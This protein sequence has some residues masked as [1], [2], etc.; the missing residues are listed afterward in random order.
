MKADGKQLS[1]PFS[2]GSGG[3]RFEANIQATFV[4][5]ML[6]SGYAPCLPAWP[7]VEIKLQGAVAGYGTDDLIVFVENPANNDRRK[8]LGQVKNSIQITAKSKIF[9]E[10]LQAAWNDFNNIEVFAKGRDVIA[11]ITGPINATD[12]DGVN[13]LLEQARH[14]RDADEFLTQI[15]RANFCSNN[16][17]N[18]LEA[19]KGHL[20]IANS[21]KEVEDQDLYD[22]LKHFHLLGYDLAKRGS[23]VASL[24]QSHIAQFNKDIPDKIWYQILSVVQ[25]FNQN[26]GSITPD[27]LPNDL[28]E[29][30]REPVI[31]HIPQSLVKEDGKDEDVGELVLTDWNK[32]PSAQK[33]SLA[34]L[35]GSWDES[36]EDD[37]EVVTKIT[38]ED[39]NGWISDLREAL[40]IHDCP[41]SYK[42]GLWSFKDRLQTW[43]ELGSR[44][45]D[46]HL[47]TLK[48]AALEVLRIDD[49]SFDLPGEERY[50][51]SIHGKVL[52]HSGSL[53]EGLAESLAL[54]GSRAVSLTHCTQ[55]KPDAISLLSVRELFEDGDWIRWGSLNRLLPVLSEAHPDE[56]LKAV[57]S[58]IVAMP[59]PFD[60]LFEQ[61]DTGVFG[62]NYITGLL[63][64]LEG[65]AWE[66]THLSRT[67][68]LLAEIAS[69]DPGGN[70]TN[71]PG[72][73]LTAIFL[74][75]LPHTLASLEKRQATL[76]TICVE[77]PEV[78]WK[79]LESLLPGQQSSSSGTHKPSWRGTI[80]DDWEKGVTNGEYWEQSRFCAELIVELAEFDVF[81]LAILTSKYD[82][83]PPPASDI[84]REKLLSEHCLKLSEEERMPLWTALVKLI[85][86]H[87][88]FPDAEWSLGDETL[89]PIEE[90]SNKLAP[91]SPRLLHR[92]IFSEA[93]AYLY[94][95]GGDWKK[96][97]K[98]LFELRKAA[99]GDILGEGGLPLVL[100]FAS[101]VSN[102]HLVGEVL[103]DFDQRE[104]DA[105]ILP[106]LLDI[107]D[108]EIWPLIKAYAS[109][110]RFMGGWQW[111]D[112]IDKAGWAPMQIAL[113][114]CA[115][116]FEKNAWDRVAQL[117]GENE[118]G[119]WKNTSIHPYNSDDDTEHALE[120]L[121]EFGRPSAAI[122][123]LTQDLFV[124][125]VINPDLACKA[126][127]ALVRAD[128]TLGR[129]D[130]YQ[131]TE[132]IKELQVN[133]ATDQ[134]KLFQVEWA[135]VAL[136]DQ[137]GDGSPITLENRL[138]SDPNFF[139]ELIQLVFRAEGAEP[140]EE[141]SE[142]HRN[143]ATNAYRLLSAWSVI[144]GARHD[145]EFNQEAFT[146]WLS[147]VE[148]VVKASGHY[149]VAMIQLGDVLVNSP[150]GNG[151]FI[152][153]VIAEAMNNKER[154]S[155]RA[156]YRT[157]VRNA[158]GVYTV[159]PE[160]KPERELAEK[161]RGQA[162]EIENAGY[163]RLATTLRD[164]ATSYDADAERIISRG[165]MPS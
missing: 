152:H 101:T 133:A 116:P 52:P 43:Q 159:D 130:S 113:L 5:L 111:F 149:D 71:R 87:R 158:R 107:A 42:D 11:L 13:G 76:K 66:D 140:E 125:K 81:K 122:E 90:I 105:E 120:K 123:G 136:L 63:R 163:H 128:E 34:M 31:A 112:D 58:A 106:S 24:L 72:N 162:E 79:L 127:L 150:E 18:K 126:L 77:Q 95:G 67:A 109:R 22:F 73:S 143:I 38:G 68:V 62:R 69:H 137:Y 74:T 55:G 104:F 36:N 117:L 110:R 94:E 61:E 134:D 50:A 156:G 97:Q 153:P 100:K 16:V 142:Q 84:L 37:I 135:Y 20:K 19:F 75:W 93:D 47:D 145:A 30:F 82:H 48:A 8:L 64:A 131:I 45:F 1:N 28:V 102:A 155:L 56:F 151:L 98:K 144:P 91:E 29:H 78:A 39:Y 32:Q 2:T 88:R 157:G 141:S 115:L 21:G 7:I 33:L 147:T 14:T 161:Y 44:I 60:K 148:N 103:A 15:A 27:T 160:A 59:S 114:L 35:I 17:R 53:R 12:T 165:G 119:Y 118:D 70:W 129:I 54:V 139:C 164:V 49:P 92:R 25:D 46:N 138:A 23:V 146:E 26:A 124:K 132:I 41:L 57:E 83:L 80:P 3:A 85:A 4:T 96:K 65:I 99:V 89:L 9:G 121:L 10:V 154:S 51:A 86:R 6:S 108:Q 40:Q